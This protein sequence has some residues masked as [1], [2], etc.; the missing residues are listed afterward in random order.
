MTL[1]ASD[2]SVEELTALCNEFQRNFKN[3]SV[4][5]DALVQEL[6]HEKTTKAK[7]HTSIADLQKELERGAAEQRQL[8]GELEEALAFKE[9]YRAASITVEHLKGRLETARRG[10]ADA[11]VEHD[12]VTA[13]LRAQIQDLLSRVENTN[14][15]QQMTQLRQQCREMEERCALVNGQ[16]LQERERHAQQDITMQSTVRE[17]LG[18]NSELEQRYRQIEGELSQ[19]RSA[20]RRSLDLQND[21]AAQRERAMAEAATATAQAA[22]SR[23]ALQESQDALSALQSKHDETIQALKHAFDEERSALLSRI[24]LATTERND[25]VAARE[26]EEERRVALERQMSKK[27]SLVRQE[28]MAEAEAIQR[29]RAEERSEWLHVE[30]KLRAAQQVELDQRQRI[31]KL[32]Q[33]ETQLTNDMHQLRAQAERAVQQ[34][35]WIHAEKE[36]ALVELQACTT[37]VEDLAN[38]LKKQDQ[39]IAENDRL[40]LA[41]QFKDAEVV[42]AK[43]TAEQAV[44]AL[45]TTEDNAD[46]R[47]M[48]LMKELKNVKRQWQ[49][50]VIRFDAMRKKLTASLIAKEHALQAALQNT[51]AAGNLHSNNINHH[52]H[53]RLLPLADERTKQRTTKVDAEEAPV[54]DAMAILQ[55]LDDQANQL[56][57]KLATLM[58]SSSRRKSPPS[59]GEGEGLRQ[60]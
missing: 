4:Q 55:P 59:L 10:V 27:V 15:E 30:S 44:L 60:S 34:E 49:N 45:R 58:S 42:D 51:T 56:E 54:T 47:S 12:S 25:A 21:A 14:D 17:L 28:M 19:M 18:K 46:R 57:A 26:L 35:A 50:D 1:T 3:L 7:L 52:L 32:E 43:H 16:L 40:R 37:R 39:V 41:L 9:K 23:R 8:K 24:A 48:I 13:Q 6:D 5:Y 33:R 11:V 20:V 36:R 22:A 53:H 2:P 38:T 31:A 29:Q